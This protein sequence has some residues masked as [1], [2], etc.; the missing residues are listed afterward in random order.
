MLVRPPLHLQVVELRFQ[1]LAQAGLLLGTP[2]GVLEL[3]EPCGLQH[4][5]PDAG[6]RVVVLLDVADR[7]GQR[8]QR[9]GEVEDVHPEHGRHRE[10][11]HHPADG[12]CG[13]V[14]LGEERAEL[15]GLVRA[16]AGGR[17]L[18]GLG[19]TGERL[20]GIHPLV[21]RAQRRQRVLHRGAQL[22]GQ[23]HDAA[24]LEVGE[25]V[26]GGWGTTR[27]L[28]PGLGL[29]DQVVQLQQPVE[30]VDPLIQRGSRHRP[31]LVRSTEVMDVHE[32]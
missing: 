8:L 16:R 7:E 26:A 10:P 18:G 27:H 25:R 23:V 12:A 2:G 1:R 4:V 3:R 29:L 21:R 28:Q 31:S 9:L 17:S 5:G 11:L 13:A 32:R 20:H 15:P 14:Q 24:Q 30:Q 6:D 22:L 19:Q